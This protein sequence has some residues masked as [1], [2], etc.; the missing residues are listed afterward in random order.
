M[1][2]EFGIRITNVYINDVKDDPKQ[3]VKKDRV[4]GYLRCCTDMDNMEK[5]TDEL[6]FHYDTFKETKA[7]MTNVARRPIKKPRRAGF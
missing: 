5:I 6:I 4:R 2:Q 7:R 3:K 1:C